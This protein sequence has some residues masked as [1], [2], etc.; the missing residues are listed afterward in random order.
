VLVRYADDLVILCRSRFRAEE[1]RR[2]IE[3]ILVTLGLRLHPDKTRIVY[4]GDGYDGFDFLGFIIGWLTPGS[5]GIVGIC[6]SGPPGRPWPRS[7]T[8]SVT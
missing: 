3:R 4:I 1:A 8:R 2:R 5:I 6:I 7:G